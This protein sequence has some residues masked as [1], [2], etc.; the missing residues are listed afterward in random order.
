L[1]RIHSCTFAVISTN[2]LLAGDYPALRR[3]LFSVVVT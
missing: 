1:S 2:R 3:G